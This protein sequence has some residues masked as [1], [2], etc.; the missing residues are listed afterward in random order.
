MARV[1]DLRG[2]TDGMEED[3]GVGF[4]NF[5]K[6]HKD[7]AEVSP[8]KRGYSASSSFLLMVY[9]VNSLPGKEE[10]G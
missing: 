10:G 1:I 9:W 6:M 4:N 2:R 3:P 8:F 5:Q 7:V